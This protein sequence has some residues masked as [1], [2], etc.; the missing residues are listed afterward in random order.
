VEKLNFV[1]VDTAPREDKSGRGGGMLDKMNGAELPF[2]VI[3]KI[4]LMFHVLLTCI[5]Q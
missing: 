2:E 3:M 4:Q 5:I 1:F